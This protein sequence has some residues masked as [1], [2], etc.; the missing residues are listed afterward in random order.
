MTR[1]AW[2]ELVAAIEDEIAELGPT[3]TDER[4]LRFLQVAYLRDIRDQLAKNVALRPVF[5]PPS[6]SAWDVDDAQQEDSGDTRPFRFS[7]E[8]R[9]GRPRE[10]SPEAPQP[11]KTAKER[12]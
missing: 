5:Q 8:L 12:K 1:R 11:D 6:R 7:D 2:N 4:K 3:Q 9:A 10:G